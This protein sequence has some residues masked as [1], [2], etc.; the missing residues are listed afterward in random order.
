MSSLNQTPQTSS[1]ALT[2]LAAWGIS[3]ATARQFCLHVV[4]HMAFWFQT[5]VVVSKKLEQF[6]K[7]PHQIV[8]RLS[9]MRYCY[10]NRLLSFGLK[11]QMPA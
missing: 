2:A 8:A 4:R 6:R 11:N 7:L 9:K 10:G 3:P 1:T 5:L